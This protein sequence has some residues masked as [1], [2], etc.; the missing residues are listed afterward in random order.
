MKTRTLGKIRAAKPPKKA[1]TIS[2]YFDADLKAA[3]ESRA[4]ASQRSLS[5]YLRWL[6]EKELA[7]GKP[8][9]E[10]TYPQRR[11]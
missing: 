7:A 3:L 4:K 10:N 11:D 2:V 5:G 1:I 6:G 8:V 9:A